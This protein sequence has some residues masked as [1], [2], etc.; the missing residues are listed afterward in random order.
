MHHGLQTCPNRAKTGQPQQIHRRRAQGRHH[1]G[2][3]AS[4]A[5]SV[6]AELGVANPVPALEASSVSHQ[7]QQQG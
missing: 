5:V 2:A 6:L 7:L 1:P 3:V 4:V